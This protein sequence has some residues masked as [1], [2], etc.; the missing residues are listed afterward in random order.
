MKRILALLA[1]LVSFSA[2]GN[3]FYNASGA[4]STGAALVSSTIR[5]EF[6]N[7]AAGFDKLPTV[8]GHGSLMCAVNSG[9]TALE[10]VTAATARSNLGLVI[11]T[12]VQAWDADLDAVA[13]LASTDSNFIVGNGSTWVAESGATVRTSLGL[14]IGTDVQ[15]YDAE[16]AA[17][18]GLTSAA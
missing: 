18:A 7:I 13:A 8:T 6:S 15:A 2:H 14:T 1:L 9:G 17:I 3:D 12:N 10:S 5:T 11:G 4:P 16:L